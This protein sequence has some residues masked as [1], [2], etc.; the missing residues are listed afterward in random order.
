MRGR[1]ELGGMNAN[2]KRVVAVCRF[3]VGV[4]MIGA[5]AWVVVYSRPIWGA[6]VVAAGVVNLV[7][8]T[9]QFRRLPNF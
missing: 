1:L 8:A 3:F 6:A 2:A 4:F 7:V 9:Y 5:G